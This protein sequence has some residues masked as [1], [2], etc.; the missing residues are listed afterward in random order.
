MADTG[1]GSSGASCNDLCGCPAPCPGGE[2]CRMSE[3]SGGDQVHNMC[4]CGEHCSC[5]PC[6]CSKNQTSAKGKALC[7]CGEGCTCATCAA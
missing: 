7:T 4:P 5:N 2:S 3:A 6:T 1:K